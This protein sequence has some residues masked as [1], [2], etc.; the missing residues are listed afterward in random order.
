MPISTDPIKID[1]LLTRRV[2]EVVVEDSLKEKLASG[3]KLRVKL[4]VDPTAPDIHLGH[5]VVLKKMREFQDMG[6]Q[7]ILIIGD[8]TA[9]IGDPSGKSKTRPMLTSKEI[10]ANAKTYLEQAGKI[11][12]MNKLEIRYNG[13]W[14]SKM[15][16]K[17]V[18]ELTGK[19][20]VARMIERED[21]KNR[22]NEGTDIGMHELFYPIMQAYDSVMIE[23]SIELGGTDQRFN[24]LAGRDLQKKMGQHQQDAMFLGPILVGTDRTQKMSK[25]LGNYIG[26][27]ESPEEIYG[28]TMS[29]PDAAMWDW[30]LMVTDVPELEIKEIRTACERGGVNPREAKAHLAREIVVAYH[31]EAD[32]AKAEEHFNRVIRDKELPEEIE[33]FVVV[34]GEHG[35][36]DLLVGSKMTSSKSEA[37]RVIEQ[38]GVKVDGEVVTDIAAIIHVKEVVLIQKGKRQFRNIVVK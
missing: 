24:I 10:K 8:Y 37:R 12:D 16:F 20:T 1:S 36:I 21:F 35:L 29:I 31:S 5:S 26:V 30:F 38:G 14:F 34:V 13:E 3:K 25:S 23:A 4:G 7:A 17:D 18:L 32:A 28:K 27:A 6:H 15:S 9:L 33:E 2:D 11:L 19:F 22:M